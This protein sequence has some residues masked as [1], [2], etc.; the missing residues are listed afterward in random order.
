M[1]KFATAIITAFLSMITLNTATFAADTAQWT[2]N[3]PSIDVFDAGSVDASNM[4]V[5]MPNADGSQMVTTSLLPPGSPIRLLMINGG[6]VPGAQIIV[7]NDRTLVPVRIISETLGAQV[8]WDANQKVVTVTDPNTT[9]VLKIGSS[10][11]TVNGDTVTLDAAAMISSDSRTYVP[12][13]FIAEAM[14]AQVG[15][16][17]KFNDTPVSQ[18]NNNQL[19]SYN[20]GIVT[21]EKTDNQPTY[22]A[23]AGLAAV[24]AASADTY[25]QVTD[26]LKANNTTFTN[27][28]PDYDSQKITYIT[29]FGRYYIYRLAG[30]ESYNILYNSYTGEIF[31]QQPGLPFLAIGEG[32]INIGWLYQ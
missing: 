31:S 23:D 14:N 15:Y 17:D 7:Q 30:F 19:L 18:Q 27:F 6:F 32:F 29:A 5:Q 3:N 13:R 12:L 24:K 26:Y 25:K 28:S 9:I 2:Q 11:A 20:V 21:I 4:A 1:K 22:S 8:D 10:E 16:T